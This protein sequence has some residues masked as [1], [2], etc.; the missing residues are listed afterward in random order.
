MEAEEIR[1]ECLVCSA[2]TTSAHLGMSICRACS[3]FYKRAKMTGVQYPCRQA[4]GK[5]GVTRV[6]K[7][8]C[9]RCR[10][11]K[12]VAMGAVY[13]GPMRLRANIPPPLLERI[14]KE[15][16]LMIERRRA[17]E[18][19]LMKNTEHLLLPHPREKIFVVPESA[20]IEISTIAMEESMEFFQ[21][22]FPALSKLAEREKEQIFKDYFIKLG[23]VVCYYLTE[24]IFGDVCDKIMCSVVTCHDEDVP[25]DFYFPDH[26]GDKEELEK[27]IRNSH[28]EHASLFLP[29]FI[30]CEL[31][32]R[33]FF[34]LAALA[35]TEHADLSISEEAQAAMREIREE[36]LNNLQCYYQN[37]MGMADFAVRLGNLLSLTHTILECQSHCREI[38]QYFS[39]FFETYM[40]DTLMKELVL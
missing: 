3:V 1:Q 30:K 17:K 5:C 27:S 20:S 23:Q 33:E 39:T 4:S 19:E 22:A 40:T 16:K 10:F 32:E 15:F 11:D 37:D 36:I 35:L 34:A 26:Q 25:I 8:N 21:K 2:P 9:R 31:T 29:Q 13:D 6:G 28:D 38:M 14:G 24:K 7:F 12:C 18:L